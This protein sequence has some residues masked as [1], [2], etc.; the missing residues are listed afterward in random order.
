MPA[1]WA[2][3]DETGEEAAE[4]GDPRDQ[5]QIIAHAYPQ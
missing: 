1:E 5:G 4:M 2:D 3:Q